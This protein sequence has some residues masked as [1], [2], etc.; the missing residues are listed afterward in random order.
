[1]N[2][3]IGYNGQ[4]YVFDDDALLRNWTFGNSDRTRTRQVLDSINYFKTLENTIDG[5]YEVEA[6]IIP[7]GWL[8][9]DLNSGGPAWPIKGW[10]YGFRNNTASSYLLIFTG[11]VLCDRDWWGGAKVWLFAIPGNTGNLNGPA[12]FFNDRANSGWD[13]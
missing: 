4:N 7:R 12:V 2:V 8:Y 6:S 1:M 3:V 11:A 10:S 9:R 5:T 13:L